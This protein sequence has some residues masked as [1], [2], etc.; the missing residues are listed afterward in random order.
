MGIYAS[1]AN[2][3]AR[4]AKFKVHLESRTLIV[5][6]KKIINNGEFKGNLDVPKVS[7]DTALKYIESL[8]DQYKHSVPS[9]RS[10]HKGKKYFK[11]LPEDKLED[12]DMRYGLLRDEAQVCLELM[13]LCFILNGSLFWDEQKMGKWF[14]QSDKDKDLIILRQWVEN[15]NN[16]NI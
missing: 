7:L 4:G 13:V 1:T 5:D 9:E 16:N 11:A 12:N 14:W 6:G 15:N 2:K 10:E 8:Y 3:V